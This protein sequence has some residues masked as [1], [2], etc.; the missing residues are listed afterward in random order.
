MTLYSF[1]WLTCDSVLMWKPKKRQNVE[2]YNSYLKK[3]GCILELWNTTT[4]TLKNGF[5]LEFYISLCQSEIN[6]NVKNPKV[7]YLIIFS[8]LND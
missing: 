4:H 2:Y 8:Q 7:C 1:I 5:I 3:N 6:L